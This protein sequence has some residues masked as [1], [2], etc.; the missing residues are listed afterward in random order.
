MVG[1]KKLNCLCLDHEHETYS[2]DSAC[3]ACGDCCL[4][5][6]DVSLGWK[7]GRCSHHSF[8]DARIDNSFAQCAICFAYD[9]EHDWEVHSAEVRA[10]S[11]A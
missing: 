7:W 9:G 3:R 11:Y 2:G 1:M 10:N 5:C 4:I 6:G 8:N